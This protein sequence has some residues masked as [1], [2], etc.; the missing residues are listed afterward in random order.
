M[1]WDL[2][3]GP[4]KLFILVFSIPVEFR[5]IPEFTPECSP[6]WSS[7]EW[8]GMAFRWN[9]FFVCYLFVMD[10]KQCLFGSVTWLL[11]SLPP[12]SR[13]TT[14]NTPP[15]QRTATTAHNDHKQ[16]RPQTQTATNGHNDH[17]TTNA[18]QTTTTRTPHRPS[19][20]AATAHHHHQPVT[21]TTTTAHKQPPAT[22]RAPRLT[23]A[24]DDELDNHHK[25]PPTS[26]M[27]TP[28]L[29]PNTNNDERP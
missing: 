11:F 29:T 3:E 9:G 15:T 22:T 1:E 8:A 24:H 13:H 18:H 17:E 20:T 25:R 12:P 5:W 7:P 26:T 23:P 14:T 19:P 27:R 28:R 10:N 6:E 21:T 16:R 4:A 2:A